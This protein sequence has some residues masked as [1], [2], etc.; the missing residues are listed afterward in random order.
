M[1]ESNESN[2]C[3]RF[4]DMQLRVFERCL[5]RLEATQLTGKEVSLAFE[6]VYDEIDAVEE[7]MNERFDRLEGKMEH[8]ESK[9]A[10]IKTQLTAIDRKFD[11][12]MRHIT[13]QSD[14]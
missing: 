6:R 9:I 10:E 11:I 1:S 4:V 8:L 3:D 5:T 2:D 14:R 12:V 7:Q 13:G